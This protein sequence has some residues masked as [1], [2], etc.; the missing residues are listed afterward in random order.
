LEKPV[1]PIRIGC[2]R[3]GKVVPRSG[4]KYC[5]RACY[6][7]AS[8]LDGF[9]RQIL[10]GDGCWIWTGNSAEGRARFGRKLSASRFSYQLFL[11]TIPKSKKVCH[12][13]D[14]GMCV[15]PGHFFLGTS[16]DNSADMV[17]KKRQAFGARHGNAKLSDD[18][19][20]QAL[21]L[22]KTGN[23]SQRAVAKQ[24]GIHRVVFN[25]IVNGHSW[26]HLNVEL[27]RRKW[28]HVCR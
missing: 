12:S 2:L 3:C 5:G 27:G 24:F 23:I 1:H 22:Y 26:R 6:L 14:D 11:G 21:A 19:I 17:A 7:Q 10:I 13:C 20:L 4:F 9:L 8:V 16:K 28:R 25:K 18:I 15:R